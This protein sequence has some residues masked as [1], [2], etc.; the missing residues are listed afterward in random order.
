[1]LI[2]ATP[3]DPG[4][5]PSAHALALLADTLDTRPCFDDTSRI[6]TARVVVPGAF[7]TATCIAIALSL[8]RAAFYT[9]GLRGWRI[10]A[11]V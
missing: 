11:G 2:E 8:A 6:L 3:A 1:V 7:E 4:R 5:E 9:S 10:T